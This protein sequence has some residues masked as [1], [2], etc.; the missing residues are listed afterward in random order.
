MGTKHEP[1]NTGCF[2]VTLSADAAIIGGGLAGLVAAHE[3]AAAGLSVVIIVKRNLCSGSSF[4]PLTGALGCQAPI[5]DADKDLFYQELCDSGQGMEDREMSRTYVEEIRDRLSLL[6]ELGICYE[7]PAGG[8]KACFAQRERTIVVLQKLNSS[9]QVIRKNITSSS[10]ITVLEYC[11]VVTLVKDGERVAGLIAADYQSKL[12]YVKAT[13][14][15]LATGG[16]GGIYKHS[17]NTDDVGGLG[18]ILAL[19]A[20]AEMV[21]LEFV[22]FIPGVITP[23][24]KLLF[25][26]TTLRFCDGLFDKNGEDILQKYLPS[27]VSMRQCLDSRAG[28]GPFTNNDESRYFDLSMMMEIL[29]TGN[30]SGF[31]LQYRKDLFESTNYYDVTYL[32]FVKQSGVDL[33]K[34][35]LRIA[36]FGHAAN[37]GVLID[38]NGL[39]TVQGLYAAGEV[40]G[41][42]HG[43]DR[44]G[45]NATGSC[46]VFGYRAA[47]SM[48][49]NKNKN[50]NSLSEK[51][52]FAQY[53]AKIHSK[54]SGCVSPEETLATVRS[55][56]WKN[57]NILRE[58][59]HLMEAQKII[60]S[61]YDEYN[62][63]MLIRAGVPIPQAVAAGSSLEMARLLLSAAEGRK[64]SRGA[65]YRKDYPEKNEIEYRKR[66]YLSLHEGKIK[67]SFR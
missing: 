27:N 42:F 29:K 20:G 66:Q 35:S 45:G 15:M 32:N 67:Q 12:Y 62:A 63:A 65:H 48:I 49:Q 56:L 10:N 54:N 4:Y 36:P 22:Q 1:N 60:Q 23:M 39:T 8:R 38:R 43:A 46:L 26:E 5:N 41:G 19:E 50:I 64:E 9:K 14:V 58:K 25:S 21:N 17:L 13:S 33:R 3:C 47:K 44:H 37:G 28:H 40:S 18:H 51:E 11:D 53:Q 24:Y 52:A 30:E 16:F 61:L 57:C 55:I 59:N 7:I 34:D 2:D 31:R 6:D